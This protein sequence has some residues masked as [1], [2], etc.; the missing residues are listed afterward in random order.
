[1]RWKNGENFYRTLITGIHP[2][3]LT[4]KFYKKI[5]IFNQFF[6]KSRIFAKLR[7]YFVLRKVYAMRRLTTFIRYAACFSAD[8]F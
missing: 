1:M 4:H 3:I 5:L 2:Q 8:F 7:I 6:D